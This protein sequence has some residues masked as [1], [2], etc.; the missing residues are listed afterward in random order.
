MNDS[1]FSRVEYDFVKISAVTVSVLFIIVF[2]C[3]F[4]PERI[5][6]LYLQE[7]IGRAGIACKSLHTI[8]DGP[9]AVS[10]FSLYFLYPIML[11]SP[12]RKK[13]RIIQSIRSIQK[14]I[15]S[16]N[17][18][19]ECV[20][21]LCTMDRLTSPAFHILTQTPHESDSP[22]ERHFGLSQFVHTIY[23][24]LFPGGRILS[25]TKRN[26]MKISEREKNALSLV[27]VERSHLLYVCQ[28]R[29]KQNNS[30][31]SE[32][33]PG[34]RRTRRAP[35]ARMTCDSVFFIF[36]WLSTETS[37]AA[38]SCVPFY[39]SGSAQIRLYWS[40]RFSYRRR[41][42]YLWRIFVQLSP[43]FPFGVC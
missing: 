19:E 16:P 27:F 4:V 24:L 17:T 35:I 25:H 10:A 37:E 1:N 23:F 20:C 15:C 32:N 3:Y 7:E 30:E 8:F 9:F 41:C 42:H 11:R 26:W 33:L 2:G 28:C 31:N 36:G 18:S 39:F 43:V 22:A 34:W 14:W 6:S 13:E 12:I 40:L 38:E 21:A 5:G 29:A